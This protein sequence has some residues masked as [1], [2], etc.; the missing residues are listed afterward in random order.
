MDSS[1][2]VSARMWRAAWAVFGL[3]FAGGTLMALLLAAGLADVPY[4]GPL[5]WEMVAAEGGCLDIAQIE[6]SALV[7][8][9]T[10]ELTA[11]VENDAAEVAAWGVHV[12]EGEAGHWE[13]V[14]PGYVRYGG[15]THAFLHVVEG[16][17]TL[18]LDL[19]PDG[20]YT[21]RVNEERASEGRLVDAV[22][23]WQPIADPGI[24]WSRLALFGK[25]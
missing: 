1:V 2:P 6:L 3:V 8:P 20:A 15:Q 24:C 4:A 11:R 12:G 23:S 5:Q 16:W 14:A 7:L 10:V 13:V 22:T 21:I 17:N 18:R 25:G 19:A 9:V